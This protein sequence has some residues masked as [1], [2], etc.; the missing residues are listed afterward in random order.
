MV[1]G[2]I[3]LDFKCDLDS[4]ILA[5]VVVLFFSFFFRS[6]FVLK[7]SL[8]FL[9]LFFLLLFVKTRISTQVLDE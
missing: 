2:V 9:F 8:V 4:F 3:L 7:P 5:A 1:V 6:I